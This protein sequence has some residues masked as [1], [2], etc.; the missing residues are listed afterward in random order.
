MIDKGRTVDFMDPYGP[1]MPS[2]DSKEYC[3]HVYKCK[4]CGN[5]ENKSILKITV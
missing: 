2:I 3:Y 5:F 1:Q 4:N